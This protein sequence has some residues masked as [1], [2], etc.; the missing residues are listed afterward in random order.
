MVYY[1]VDLILVI[2]LLFTSIRVT[3]MR[4]QLQ[5]LRAEQSDFALVLGKTTDAVDDMV[6]MVRDFTGDGKQ[7]V[8][9][10]GDKIEEARNAIADIDARSGA[11]RGQA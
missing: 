6:S 9:A 2:A 10:L 11:S 3:Q 5:R 8:T 1:L 7:L 4:G